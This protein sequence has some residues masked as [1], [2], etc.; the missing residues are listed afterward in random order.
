MK[1]ND[2]IVCYF[3][4]VVADVRVLQRVRHARINASNALNLPSD[5]TRVHVCHLTLL[6]PF[7]TTYKDASLLNLRSTIAGLMPNHPLYATRFRLGR[8][9]RMPFGEK[10]VL[11]FE[12]TPEGDQSK[13]NSF[14]SYVTAMRNEVMRSTHFGWRDS[15]P[16]KFTPHIT[17]LTTH[18]AQ[19]PSSNGGIL[20]NPAIDKMVKRENETVET[21]PFLVT[22]P[23]LYAKYKT[24]W[25]ILSYNPANDCL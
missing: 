23:I 9:S 15:I 25:Q 1:E 3:A 14:T 7:F 13:D 8:L 5:E 19:E 2:R 24:G 12:V 6:P 22:Y 21:L 10:A 4:A 11:Y 20:W 18:D 17:V 16:P